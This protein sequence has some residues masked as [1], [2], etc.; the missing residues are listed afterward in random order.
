MQL[1]ISYSSE[2][3]QLVD[4]LVKILTDGGQEVWIDDS[5]RTGQQW[6]QALRQAIHKS[7]G[8][9]LCLSP[10]WLKSPWCQWEFI[11]AAELGKKV[12]PILFTE[13]EIPERI[14]KYQYADFT[15]GFQNTEKIQRFLDDLL[16]LASNVEI[17]S[18]DA[19]K[20]SEL[21]HQINKEV[22]S[23]NIDDSL[24][25]INQIDQN[26]T[27]SHLNQSA[28]TGDIS[29]STVKINQH[30]TNI[31]SQIINQA[32]KQRNWT[33]PVVIGLLFALISTIAGV[34]ALLPDVQRENMLHS[35]GFVPASIT[36]L[37][38]PTETPLPSPTPTQTPTRLSA[39]GFNVVV[40]GFGF[41]NSDG[42][43]VENILAD[44]MSDIVANE[45]NQITQIDNTIGWRSNGVGRILGETPAERE[46]QAAEIANILG[47]DVIV[48]G[49]VRSDGIYNIFEPEF[50][51]TAEFAA[52]EPELIGADTLGNPLEF[53]GN[54][55][56]QILAANSFQ[57]RLGV[58]RFFL[59]G[60]AFYLAG[61]FEDSVESFE[62][63]LEVESDGLEVVHIFA[64]NA[65]IRIPDA[66]KAI[67]FYNTALLHR[68]DYARGLVGRGIALYRLALDGAG[69]NPP[70]YNPLL[71][72]TVQD[73][74]DIEAEL[75]TEPQLLG[76]LAR[77]CYEQASVSTDQPETADVDVKVAFGIGQ[78]SLWL[79]LNNYGDYWQVVHD[80]LTLVV[81]L[82][83]ASSEARQSRIRA[84]TA[85]SHAWLGL[86]LLSLDGN[87]QNA[88]CEAL[89]NYRTAIGL[90]RLDVNRDYNQRWIDLYGQ[91]VGAL[92]DWLT[93]RDAECQNIENVLTPSIQGN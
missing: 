22:I 88:V 8:I 29:R 16:V 48:Y 53:V 50:Y 91:Q 69:N 4:D 30:S 83:N 76:E 63:A 39:S 78:T 84:A 10:N 24:V 2:D 73:C 60:L 26:T 27:T 67:T 38:T 68:P 81:D 45:L 52:L 55:E 62:Q 92:E 21:E 57:R 46:A 54:S 34:V 33:I 3:R 9:V 12:V 71:E 43:I 40:A 74:S 1:F 5:I 86:R 80:Q 19:D 18:I 79:S 41:E 42:T 28:T 6:K 90:L 70:V 47:A 13:S 49:I 14:A 58:M 56:D 35:I 93:N 37:P 82:Y 11:T 72:L 64:G 25:E 66:D 23:G 87:D 36:P 15:G 44:D 85:H 65:A 77:I 32:E 20:K 7:D 75:P 59:R 89:N 31:G 17:S 51:I 61:N